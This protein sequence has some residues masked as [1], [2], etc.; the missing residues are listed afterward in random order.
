MRRRLAAVLLPVLLVPLAAC[1]EREELRDEVI[2]ALQRTKTESFRFQYEDD[3]PTTFSIVTQTEVPAQK[4][5]VN[6]LFED[7][8]RF[9]ARVSFNGEDGFDEVVADDTL[10]MR[11]ISPG[12]L[13]PLINKDKVADENAPTD[14]GGVSSL[15]VLQSRRWVLDPTGAP[16]VT[17]ESGVTGLGTDPVLDAVTVLGYVETA[18]AEAQS[19]ERFDPEDISP[20]YSSSEDT[21][22]KPERGSGVTRYDLRRPRLPPPGQQ[23]VNTQGSGRP[24]TNHF[25]RMAIYVK[26]GKVVQV[27]EAIDLRGKFI[28]DVAKYTRTLFRESKVPPE[29]MRFLD[30]TEKQVPEEERGAFYLTI[31]STFLEATGEAPI[32]QRTMTAAFSDFGSDV[33]VDLPTSDVAKGSLGFLVVT[34]KGKKSGESGDSAGGG[35]GGGRST[36]TT[37]TT[38]AAP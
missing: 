8:F 12:R 31:L 35:S 17:S 18:I 34:E 19:V 25:R 37:T 16:T 11:F 20:A 6:G 15:E 13:N 2:A 28:A 26:D 36:A 1:G 33:K 5:S 9:K 4:I 30:E 10:A 14:L 22:P 27:R 21:F 7:D 32:L 38:T 29:Q 24:Q 3:R 23:I